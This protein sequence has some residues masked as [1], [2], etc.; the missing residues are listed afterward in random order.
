M[1][2]SFSKTAPWLEKWH[3]AAQDPGLRV[4][5]G[6]LT[7]S[8]VFGGVSYYLNDQK[9]KRVPV[10]FSEFGK[11]AR[12][13]EQQGQNVPPLTHFY[14]VTNDITMQVFEAS[15]IA[16]ERSVFT[17]AF[18]SELEFKMDKGTRVHTQISKRA[19]ELP[20]VAGE[21]LHSLEKFVQTVREMPPVIDAFDN[22]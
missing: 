14:S 10:A 18:P 17:D 4:V 13:F 5:I 2:E 22:S 19:I 1:Q 16:N 3:R 20:P 9:A 11:T 21:A 12:S 7:R 15:N 8:T 6:A